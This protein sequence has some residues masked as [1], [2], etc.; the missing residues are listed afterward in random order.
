MP[1]DQSSGYY[2]DEAGNNHHCR[3]TQSI[4]DGGGKSIYSIDYD[5]EETEYTTK[6]DRHRDGGSC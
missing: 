2:M 3:T 6:Y 5:E 1:D 4:Y